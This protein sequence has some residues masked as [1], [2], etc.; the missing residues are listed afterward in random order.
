M[1]LKLVPIVRLLLMVLWCLEGASIAAATA[2]P[3][4]TVPEAESVESPLSY[5]QQRALADH[6]APRL[7]FHPNETFF[8]CSPLFTT[9]RRSGLFTLTTESF[10]GNANRPHMRGA[11]GS[12]EMRTR[13]YE[14]MSLLERL[15]LAKIYFQAYRL[16]SN[17]KAR[18]V[19]EYWLYFLQNHYRASSGLI[20]LWIDTSHPNDMEHIFLMLEPKSA[21]EPSREPPT[22]FADGYRVKEIFA[23]AHGDKVP[24]NIYEFQE[25]HETSRA[26]SFLVELGSHALA[27]DIDGDGVF[28]P[29]RD[30]PSGEKFVWG[31]RDHGKTWA[32][33]RPSYMRPRRDDAITLDPQSNL[34][35]ERSFEDSARGYY[36]LEHVN[37][38][39]DQYDQLDL[40]RD[41]I[42]D[43]F[44]TGTLWVKRMFG[45]SNGGP[46][47]LILPSK[48]ENF[49]KP[50]RMKDSYARKEQGLTMGFTNMFSG[51]TF[52][53]GG[54]QT[55]FTPTR[56]LPDV[57]LDAQL[58]L[59]TEG[60]DFYAAEILGYYPIDTLSKLFIGGGWIT[61]SLSAERRQF[62]LVTGVE[63][64]LGR[65]RF[66]NAFRS[67]GAVSPASI[68]FRVYL[69]LQ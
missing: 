14:S 3:P 1:R 60:N 26:P 36:R 12:V 48:H 5:A 10:P 21:Y 49:K 19:V 11:M 37:V 66:R 35:D 4:L 62:N 24:N 6:F 45:W 31:I 17:G 13:R 50:H 22:I 30:S 34:H 56:L 63:F 9:E 29:G 28:T 38:L 15:K 52:F 51:Y 16:S 43:I 65:F 23:S 68:D 47:K 44:R 20:P 55:I 42:A 40:S 59:T 27:P 32:S 2:P 53:G 67:S 39:S 64:S 7:V 54:R 8:P 33:Y 18:I 58:F 69:F 41:Q 61:N 46:D 25:G 57:V